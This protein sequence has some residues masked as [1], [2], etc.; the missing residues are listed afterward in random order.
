MFT[1]GPDCCLGDVVELAGGSW[2]GKKFRDPPPA[3]AEAEFTPPGSPGENEG[4]TM[5]TIPGIAEERLSWIVRMPAW[6]GLG[7]S[8]AEA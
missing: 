2:G 5:S 1:C 7:M 3:A 8:R 6:F 4:G